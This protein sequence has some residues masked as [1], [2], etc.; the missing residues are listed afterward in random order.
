MW[1]DAGEVSV[2]ESVLRGAAVLANRL[3]SSRSSFSVTAHSMSAARSPLGTWERM[4][5]ASLSSL[6]RSSA[7]AVNCAL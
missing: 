2:S 7:L 1:R 6:S 5:A 4:R 3:A